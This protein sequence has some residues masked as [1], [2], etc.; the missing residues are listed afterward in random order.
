MG[1]LTPIGIPPAG[2]FRQEEEAYRNVIP[3]QESSDYASSP[4][5]RGAGNSRHY[6]PGAPTY[7]TLSPI[8]PTS[9]SS[10]TPTDEVSSSG[11]PQVAVSLAISNE[12]PSSSQESQSEQPASSFTCED[13]DCQPDPPI[14]ETRR[15]LK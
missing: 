7:A 5:G 8:E 11:G 6:S 10:Y 15:D 13:P 3:S 9:D 14:Y 12:T 1:G 4:P 2:G